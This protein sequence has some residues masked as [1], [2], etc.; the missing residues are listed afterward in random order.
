MSENGAGRPVASRDSNRLNAPLH[1]LENG[2]AEVAV[3][4]HGADLPD[5]CSWRPDVRHSPGVRTGGPER[6]LCVPLPSPKQ[7]PPS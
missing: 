4:T 2:H 3:R 6:H 1:G 7:P 5:R